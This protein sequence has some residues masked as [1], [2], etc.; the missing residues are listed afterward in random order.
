MYMN[1]E[2]EYKFE[3]QGARVYH[4]PDFGAVNEAVR[5]ALEPQLFEAAATGFNRP[6]TPEFEADVAAHL[7]GG[8]LYTIEEESGDTGFAVL[9]D[10][11]Q[12]GA[13]YVAGIVKKPTAP[14][15]IVEEIVRYHLA[16]TG[17][18][19]AA[20]RTQNDRVLEIMANI[21]SQLVAVDQ[22]AQDREVDLLLKMGLFNPSSDIDYAHLIHRGYYGGPMIG[23]G[24]RRR[25]RNP[26]ITSYTDRLDYFAGDAAYGVGYI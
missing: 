6:L 17:F 21:S 13:L 15:R 11:P 10:F 25:S 22:N 20:V 12:L 23:S 4:T 14:S 26:R 16:K 9:E 1:K 24:T 3:Y 7:R 8:N 18:S 19:V 2:L 5:A